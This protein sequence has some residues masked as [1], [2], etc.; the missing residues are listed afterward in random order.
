MS[1]RS[2][3]SLARLLLLGIL[4]GTVCTIAVAESPT[5]YQLRFKF[6]P[7]QE[8]YYIT[9][10]DAEYLVE[11]SQARQIIPHTSMTIRHIKMLSLNADGSAE[12][13]LMIDRARMTAQ[14]EGVDSLYD[15]TDAK[16]VPTEFSAVHQSI[17]K[18]VI[19]CMTT[20]GIVNASVQDPNAN[21]EQNDLLFL[22]PEQPLAIG[23]IW[24]DHFETSVQIDAQSKLNRLIKLQRRYELQSVENGMATIALVTVPLSPINSPFQ[25]TQLVQRKYSG[26]I[27]FDID[28]GCLVDRQFKIDEKIVDH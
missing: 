10:N 19:V 8:L 15:S 22:L 24:K 2:F 3:P 21:V 14:N 23:G 18:P 27:L 9:Q 7:G 17:G 11:H 1:Q 6:T 13:E 25:E 26:T 28:Q 4:C 20:R 12:V 16:H 5:T